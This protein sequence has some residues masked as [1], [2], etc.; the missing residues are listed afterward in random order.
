[1][2]KR[3]PLYP[4]HA[5]TRLGSLQDYFHS[6][7]ALRPAHFSS[8]AHHTGIH[9]MSGAGITL[10]GE[11]VVRI[12]EYALDIKNVQSRQPSP[13][14]LVRLFHKH[15]MSRAFLTFGFFDVT[16]SRLQTKA[17]QA[18]HRNLC[19][20]A[21]AE[22]EA[23]LCLGQEMDDTIARLTGGLRYKDMTAGQIA[24]L[25]F[26]DVDFTLDTQAIRQAFATPENRDVEERAALALERAS[27]R[28]RG[29]HMPRA[30][31]P[32]HGPHMRMFG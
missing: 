17:F 29:Q 4:A 30:F 3:I 26:K 19:A 14:Q 15:L 25:D 6:V 20:P 12:Y 23:H 18:A 16:P 22:I 9:G 27:L 5:P 7:Y 2:S 10:G 21:A 11:I 31:S 28:V 13:Y 8:A 24:R 1:M 32:W